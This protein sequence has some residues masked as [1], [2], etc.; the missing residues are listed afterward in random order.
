MKLQAALPSLQPK[1]EKKNQ[2]YNKEN[3]VYLLWMDYVASTVMKGGYTE[4]KQG[5]WKPSTERS[6]PKVPLET[7]IAKGRW[8]LSLAPSKLN[9]RKPD[10]FFCSYFQLI[11]GALTSQAN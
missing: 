7:M 1:R 6:G 8:A 5:G 3:K 9:H 4:Q 10:L 11:W 2:T